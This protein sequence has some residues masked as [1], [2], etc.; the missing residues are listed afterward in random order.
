MHLSRSSHTA[1]DL[2]QYQ[3][4]TVLVA[5]LPDG[6]EISWYGRQIARCRST[7]YGSAQTRRL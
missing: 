4:D 6:L 7:D 2:I 1:H 5:D 3:Q